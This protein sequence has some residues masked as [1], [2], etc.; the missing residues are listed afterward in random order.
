[1]PRDDHPA[2]DNPNNISNPVTTHP[3]IGG[4]NKKINTEVKL[5]TVVT[6]DIGRKYLVTCLFYQ[7]KDLIFATWLYNHSN[8]KTR[9]G[10]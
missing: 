8:L 4:T 3:L 7:E 1:M 9:R 5:K 2:R 6:I 10:R